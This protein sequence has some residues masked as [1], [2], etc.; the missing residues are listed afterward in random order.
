M[1]FDRTDALGAWAGSVEV[2]QGIGGLGA[3]TE[4][5]SAKPLSRS[6]GSAAF[7][8]LNL[9][10][11]RQQSLGAGL[12]LQLAGTAQMAT[13]SLLASE[14]FGLGGDEFGRAFDSSQVLGDS[15]YALRAE[16][17][18]SFAY[19]VGKRGQ[20]VTQPYIFYDYGQVLR[21]TPT[22]AEH[23]QDTL[24]SAG[25]G[26]R[27]SL[28]DSFSMQAELAFPVMRT[29]SSTNSDPRFFMSLKGSF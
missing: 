11:S 7:S 18:R 21:K 15:G 22:T 27:Q 29:D 26:V 9:Q 17:Q 3:I 16:L 23:G 8:K 10:L 1:N 5:T 13:N 2:S 28:N 12:N 20:A 4:G 6:S 14:Q 19:K 24:S 25:L